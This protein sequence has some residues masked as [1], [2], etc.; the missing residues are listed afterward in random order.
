MSIF[1]KYE[2]IKGEA[3]DAGYKDWLD[4][5]E[6]SWGV[7]RNLTSNT[8]TSKDRESANAEIT[9][10]TLTRRMDKATPD[11]FMEACCGKG[12]KVEI[13]LTKTGGGS[14]TEPFMEYKL[15]NALISH[16]SVDA[17]TQDQKHPTESITIS[18][19]K[20]ESKYTP[21]DDKG[22]AEASVAVGF[23]TTTN[24]KS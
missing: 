9:D 10:L 23:D 20:I 22:K 14:G 8:A 1:M 16:Y 17:E 24:E 13:H 15:E 21:Y 4:V 12:K 18:F 11:L 2:G 5:D 3:T 7:R 6:I 19:Q